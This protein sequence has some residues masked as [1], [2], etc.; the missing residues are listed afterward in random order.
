[1]L[2]P[3]DLLRVIDQTAREQGINRAT[4]IRTTMMEKLRI[5]NLLNITTEQ[6]VQEVL[7]GRH[8]EILAKLYKRH[9]K[10]HT[11]DTELLRFLMKEELDQVQ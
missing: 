8:A 7:L 1:L 4:F 10:L 6:T 3:S 5:N 11:Y 2:L 9:P